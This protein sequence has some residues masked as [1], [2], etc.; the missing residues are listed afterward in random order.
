M[1]IKF[2][3]EL[4]LSDEH[5]RRPRKMVKSKEVALAILR[6][7]LTWCIATML[8]FLNPDSIYRSTIRRV[9]LASPYF[10]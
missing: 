3:A 5:I 2:G 6:N 9:G 8:D 1:T 7:K 4:M 10:G